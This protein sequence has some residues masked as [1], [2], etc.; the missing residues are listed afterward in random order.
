MYREARGT[1]NALSIVTKGMYKGSTK[2]L[3]IVPKGTRKAV[4]RVW[5]KRR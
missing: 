3:S 5:P 2:A 1:R 4:P